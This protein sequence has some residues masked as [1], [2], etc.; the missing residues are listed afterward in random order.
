[1][2]EYKSDFDNFILG[3]NGD[4]GLGIWWALGLHNEKQMTTRK[5]FLKLKEFF[6][7]SILHNRIIEY[8][9]KNQQAIFSGDEPG[10]VFDRIFADFPLDELPEYD[11]DSD[12]RFFAYMAVKFDGWAVLNEGTTLCIPD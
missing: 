2:V 3:I 11:G 7:Y 8:D 9:L 1:M 6:E 5:K 10:T 12:N 4:T